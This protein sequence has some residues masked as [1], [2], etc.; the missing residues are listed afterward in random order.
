MRDTLEQLVAR[1][2]HRPDS[3]KFLYIL[4][5]I[6]TTAREDNPEEVVAAWQ[7]ALAEKG[8]TAGRF[9]AIYNPDVAVPIEDPARR[10]R[11]E[12][13]SETD[14][15][16]IKG[17]IREVAVSRSYR[18]VG[19]LEKTA[20]TIEEQADTLR[21]ALARWRRRVLWIDGILFVLILGGLLAWT[22]HLGYWNGIV[23]SPPWLDSFKE[24]T[25]LQIPAVLILL[26]L[27]VTVHLWVRRIAAHRIVEPGLAHAWDRNSRW[28]QSV[29]RNEPRGWGRRA[30]ERL[31]QA[32]TDAKRYIQMLNDHFTN[33]SGVAPA[34]SEEPKSG[35]P[36][37]LVSGAEVR[38]LRD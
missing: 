29:L 12:T 31:E 2:I 17:R 14:L 38:V 28:W 35:S 13:K 18:V 3:G 34:T 37:R 36:P 9:Y 11:F 21:G 8:L 20:H 16:E 19:M 10:T 7:R 25:W 6:D 33:P 22:I 27:I 24:H 15:T 5:Q 23:F 26:A 1:T 32:R 4:N 30:R